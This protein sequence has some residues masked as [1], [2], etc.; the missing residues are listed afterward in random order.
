[1]RLGLAPAQTRAKGLNPLDSI[2]IF[3]PMSMSRPRDMQLVQLKLSALIKKREL[4]QALNT[5]EFARLA[6]ISYSQARD[7]F[8]KPGFPAVGNV[9]FWND[10]VAWRRAQCGLTAMLE[11][12]KCEAVK[13]SPITPSR[14]SS[15]IEF[16]GKAAQ[17][18]AEAR[19]DD[20]K[21]QYSPR[22]VQILRKA[23]CL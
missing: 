4:D 7:W 16:T 21:L 15:T 9:V 18:L 19:V 14:L 8:H 11:Q 12:A 22:V 5:K 3:H 13:S 23:G 20:R 1:M 2:V 10:F 6:G 17:I